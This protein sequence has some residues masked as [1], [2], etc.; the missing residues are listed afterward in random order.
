MPAIMEERQLT[1]PVLRLPLFPFRGGVG[2]R[3]LMCDPATVGGASITIESVNRV[4]SQTL[5]SPEKDETALMSR[6]RE[7]TFSTYLS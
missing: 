6:C 4:K 1:S 7:H 5:L 3:R 2:R